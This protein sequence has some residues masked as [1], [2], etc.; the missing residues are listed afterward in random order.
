MNHEKYSLATFSV[1]DSHC[2]FWT[3][4]H[5]ILFWGGRPQSYTLTRGTKYVKLSEIVTYATHETLL[6]ACVATSDG[7]I[8]LSWKQNAHHRDQKRP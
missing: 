7:W 8:L 1:E 5:S 6:L 2:R 4:K 3:T